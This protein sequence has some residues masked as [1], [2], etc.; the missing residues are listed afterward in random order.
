VFVFRDPE[1]D[2]VN[3][4]VCALAK[5]AL[6]TEG[7]LAVV[8]AGVSQ[9]IDQLLESLDNGVRTGACNLLGTLAIHESTA[10]AAWDEHRCHR[11]VKLSWCV[12]LISIFIQ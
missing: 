12:G 2:L 7:A 9:T 11:L 10:S 8:E 5:I 1:T 3:S 6:Q 4:A